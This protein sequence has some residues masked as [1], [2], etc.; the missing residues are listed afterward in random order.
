MTWLLVGVCCCRLIVAQPF[1][2]DPALP[3]ATGAFVQL[4]YSLAAK[5]STWWNT[6]L[7]AM[8]SIGIDTVIVQYVAYNQAYFYPTGVAG[9]R[10]ALKR[11]KA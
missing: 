2:A 7:S 1:P 3:L 10:M 11:S 6:E 9:G 8:R 5:S 4:N